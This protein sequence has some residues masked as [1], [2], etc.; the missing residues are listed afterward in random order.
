MPKIPKISPGAKIFKR[1]L[2]RGLSS[3]ENLR[4]RIDWVSLIV[5]SKFTVLLCISL[6]LRAI[7]EYKLPGGLYL[8]GRF[9]EG[10]FALPFWEAYI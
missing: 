5:G 9:N 6:Y 2:S 1:P 3:G 7:S 10:L 4:S 8:E